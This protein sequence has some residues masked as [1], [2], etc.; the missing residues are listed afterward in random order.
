[1]LSLTHFFTQQNQF[2]MILQL[3]VSFAFLDESPADKGPIGDLIIAKLT[4]NAGD[5]P[6]LPWTILQLTAAND[7]VRTRLAEA[8][9]GD[10]AGEVNLRAAEKDWDHKFSDTGKYVNYVAKGVE[11][12]IVNAGYTA[13]SAES[14]PTPIPGDIVGFDVDPSKTKGRVNIESKA[15]PHA[16]AYLYIAMQGGNFPGPGGPEMTR[17]GNQF[18]FNFNGARIT[19]LVDTHRKAHID[20]LISSQPATV[21]AA[22]VNRAGVGNMTDPIEVTPQ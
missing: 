4:A 11:A 16:E 1:L 9:T 18:T 22:A 6:D 7:L 8:A 14:H 5:Y 19:F 12:K 17:V 21:V 13:T 10:H 3:K 15:L 2:F 20:A